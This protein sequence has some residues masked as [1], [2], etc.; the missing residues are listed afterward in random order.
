[1]KQNSDNVPCQRHEKN[2]ENHFGLMD[3]FK[4]EHHWHLH[5]VMLMVN[6]SNRLNLTISPALPIIE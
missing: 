4:Y 2:I 5:C 6:G 3:I 1:M